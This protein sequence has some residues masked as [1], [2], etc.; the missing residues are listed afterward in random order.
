MRWR[1]ASAM[2]SHGMLQW[3]QV[4]V[5]QCLSPIRLIEELL[6]RARA[7]AV[8]WV[9]RLPLWD[10]YR[11]QFPDQVVALARVISRRAMKAF[12]LSLTDDGRVLQRHA[13]GKA[14]PSPQPTLT[15]SLT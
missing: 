6:P 12:N 13:E 14:L 4:F 15:Y 9:R 5:S 11:G 3:L 10:E 2:N 7:D 8:S 1:M